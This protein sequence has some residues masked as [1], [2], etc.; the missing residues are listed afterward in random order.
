MFDDDSTALAQERGVGHQ[1]QA[2][3]R[4]VRSVGRVEEDPMKAERAFGEASQVAQG[5]RAMNLGRV[6]EAQS[7]DVLL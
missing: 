7:A 4:Q 6:T 1:A 3:L 5:I 2:L